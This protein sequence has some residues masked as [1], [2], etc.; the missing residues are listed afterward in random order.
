MGF[1]FILFYVVPLIVA[2][3]VFFD[4]QKHGYTFWQGLLWAIG[5]FFILIIFLPLYFFSRN[6]RRK[7]AP[8]PGQAQA[9]T[10]GTPC[11]YCGQPYQGDP[12]TCPNCGQNL[13][14]Q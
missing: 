8:V 14:T 2:M 6:K 7:M 5:V 10:S 12:K 4:S 9:P 13:K 3:W 11:F 1:L